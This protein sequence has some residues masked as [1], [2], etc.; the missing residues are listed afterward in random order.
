MMYLTIIAALI[1]I[2]LM[3]IVDMI[4]MRK[5][6]KKKTIGTLYIQGTDIYCEFSTELDEIKKM[7]KASINIEKL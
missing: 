6:Y 3:L 2:I 7:D 1:L 5:R 4:S